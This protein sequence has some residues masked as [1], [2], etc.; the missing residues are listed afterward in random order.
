MSNRTFQVFVSS[1]F[2]DLVEERNALQRYVFPELAR[3]C[4]KAGCRFHAIDLRWGISE[5]AGLDQRTV[6]ICLR[7]VV[8]CRATSPRPNFIILLGDRYGWRP[9]PEQIDATEFEAIERVAGGLGLMAAPLLRRW[10]RLDENA[11]PPTYRLRPRAADEDANYTR[12]DVWRARVESPLRDLFAACLPALSLPEERRAVYERSLTEREIMAGALHP[13]L[14]DVH[15]HVFAYFRTIDALERVDAADGAVLPDLGRWTDLTPSGALDMDARSRLAAL[16]GRVRDRL[17]E[18][19]CRTYSTRGD[20]EHLEALCRD[21]LR[22]LG[23]VIEAEIAKLA[24]GDARAAEVEAHRQFGRLRG[25]EG[26]FQG[27]EDVLG[28]IAEYLAADGPGR[29]LVVFGPAGSGKS[30]V[31]ARAAEQAD[32]RPGVVVRRFVGVTPASVDG[33]SLLQG[34]CAELDAAT[35]RR[36]AVPAAARPSR[37]TTVTSSAPSG[38]ASAGRTHGPPWR[39]SSTPST[40]SP[41]PTVPGPSPGSPGRFPPTPGWSSPYSAPPRRKPKRQTPTRRAP[42]PSCSAAPNPPTLCRWATSRW[43]T[44]PAC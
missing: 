43:P 1:T 28:R 38:I 44:R 34:L 5:E 7:E 39:S 22:D 14:T 12:I 24:A 41:R 11:V 27:R 15:E 8:R 2:A 21:V 32:G 26:H 23:G 13:D 31:L 29:P 30:A 18:A 17:G 9:I 16:R 4:E 20:D 33:R 42:S 36:A 19:R 3:L 37:P 40:G 25:T 35:G 6:D 10:Y